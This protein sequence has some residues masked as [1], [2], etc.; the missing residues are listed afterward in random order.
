[1]VSEKSV[2]DRFVTDRS[3][4][5]TSV[6]DRNLTPIIQKPEVEFVNINQT[7]IFSRQNNLSE[8]LPE[9][10]VVMKKRKI[11]PA[12]PDRYQFRSETRVI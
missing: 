11:M 1:M 12:K 3:V 7:A 9:R 10:E 2:A 4:A 5:D 6:A 8:M